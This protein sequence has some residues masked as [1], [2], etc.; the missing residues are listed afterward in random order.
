MFS[1]LFD[2]VETDNGFVEGIGDLITEEFD[3]YEHHQGERNGIP[4]KG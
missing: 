4:N 3:M 1:W 2:S